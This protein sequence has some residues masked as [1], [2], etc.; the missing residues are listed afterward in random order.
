MYAP[1]MLPH[2]KLVVSTSS[3]KGY[4]RAALKVMVVSLSNIGV[5]A[6]FNDKLIGIAGQFC[7]IKPFKLYTIG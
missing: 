6:Q 1:I 7:H 2:I 3:P 5:L 4:N